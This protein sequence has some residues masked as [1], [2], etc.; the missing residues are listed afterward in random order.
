MVAI[1]RP[2][3][4]AATYADI[5]ALPSH[6]VGEIIDGD[7][8]VS[9]RPAVPHAAASSAIAFEL[10]GPFQFGRG[11]PG[12]WW[13]LAEPEL[14]LQAQVLVPDLAGWRKERMPRR[15]R[16]PAIELAPD[17]VC[18]V[19][20]ISTGVIDRTKKSR[21]YADA[22]VRWMW[23]VDPIARTLEVLRLDGA[24]WIV[25]ANFGDTATVRAE[26]FDAIE[27]DLSLWWLTEDDPLPP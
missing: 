16:T 6:L 17:W 10:G 3:K 4:R 13:L 2:T 26:P 25:A 20:S 8:Y 19:L 15:P 14:H 27:L 5:E 18:E 23:L 21:A 24:Q 9:P 22:G 12:G 11:G 7:L 1:V